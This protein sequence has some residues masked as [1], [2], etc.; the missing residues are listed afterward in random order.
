MGIMDWYGVLNVKVGN[1]A[2]RGLFNFSRTALVFRPRLE[3]SIFIVDSM[4]LVELNIDFLGRFFR[5]IF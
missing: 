3:K 2:I 1:D 4:G 5:S